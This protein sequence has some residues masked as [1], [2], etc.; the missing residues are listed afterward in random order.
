[1]SGSS[2]SVPTGPDWQRL[3]PVLAAALMFV[4]VYWVELTGFSLSID[5]EI[6]TFESGRA[7]VWLQQARWGMSL[8]TWILPNFEA[9]PL[10]S[11]L[12]LG[13]G[14]VAATDRALR[15]LRIGGA[16][17]WAFALVFAGFPTWLHIAQ[18]NTL[19][20]GFGIGLA[21]ACW[22]AAAC[23]ERA[24]LPWL[25][26]VA[27]L[28]FAT[29]VYQTLAVFSA[30]YVLLMLFAAAR[31][32]EAAGWMAQRRLAL[33]LATG[34]VAGLLLYALVQASALAAFGEHTQYVG[35]FVQVDRLQADFAGGVHD[36]LRFV[37]RMLN[38]HSQMYLHWGAGILFMSWLGLLFPT[39]AEPDARASGW[40]RRLATWLVALLGLSLVFVPTLLTYGTLPMRAQVAW[41]LLAAW[42]A[43]RCPFPARAPWLRV[44]ALA[45]FA[46]V[47]TS[48]GATLF[49][50]DQVVRA[51]DREISLRLLPRILHVAGDAGAGK[52][53]LLAV[54]GMHRFPLAG[55]LQSAEMFGDSFF[56]HD[57]G[58]V[59]RI[60]RYWRVLGIENIAP[61]ALS[62][63]ADLVAAAA[64]MPDWPA[65]GSVR[66]VGDV[67][68]VRFGPATPG[69]LAKH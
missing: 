57:G 69:Q 47:A 30:M 15:D 11:T 27:L 19:A 59:W 16:Q 1:M 49:Y 51:S 46:T 52:P 68:V 18:F 34:W 44:L 7:M 20:A 17:R 62:A 38:G 13:V 63:R 2:A 58:N 64:E 28:A 8:V 67:V 29:A 53:I 12:L 23:R 36:S 24:L 35:G 50:V 48:I 26:G 10:L 54:S 5:E 60:V 4:L 45:Y 55:Q 65:P 56:E 37:R 9:I 21:A 31:A 40:S 42:L 43:A 66:R 14:L 39:R 6:A 41:P 3:G 25:A 32:P 61:Q 22:G 33:R